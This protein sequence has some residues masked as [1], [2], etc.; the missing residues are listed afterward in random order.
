MIAGKP[1]H[2]EG[3]VGFGY[4]TQAAIG[5]LVATACASSAPTIV[6]P[7]AWRFS[8]IDEIY[9]RAVHTPV[10]AGLPAITGKA[11]AIPPSIVSLGGRLGRC[12][13]PSTWTQIVLFPTTLHGQWSLM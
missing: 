10:G 9:P 3:G 4:L 13:L 12:Y 5:T 6:A 8:S 11:G 7:L 1:A 2:R